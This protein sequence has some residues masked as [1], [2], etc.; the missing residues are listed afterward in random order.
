MGENSGVEDVFLTT[1]LF[2]KQ[3]YQI[4][5]KDSLENEHERKRQEK[6]EMIQ[7]EFY[8]KAMTVGRIKPQRDVVKSSNLGEKNMWCCV[9]VSAKEDGWKIACAWPKSFKFFFN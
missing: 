9:V 3:A 2:S 7:R 1:D 6:K 5:L 8:K 4:L